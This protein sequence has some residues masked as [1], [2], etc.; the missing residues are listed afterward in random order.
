MNGQF[1]KDDIV[2]EQGMGASPLVQS[3]VISIWVP[4]RDLQALG[5]KASWSWMPELLA[6]AKACVP[7]GV[8]A[9]PPV[10]MEPPGSRP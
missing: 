10:F 8:E 6:W 7:C 5:E 3:R 1:G 2:P 4:P 9:E